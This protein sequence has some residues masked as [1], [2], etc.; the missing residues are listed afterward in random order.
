M[1][2]EAKCFHH[3]VKLLFVLSRLGIRGKAVLSCGM[4]FIALPI[5]FVA[6]YSEDRVS[7]LGQYTEVPIARSSLILQSP[8]AGSG[9]LSTS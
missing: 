7:T 4:V 8:P 6:F 9:K 5:N 3:I 2:Y 1:Q